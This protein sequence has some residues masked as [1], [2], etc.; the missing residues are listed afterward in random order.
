[1][2][3]LQ[4]LA[5]ALKAQ[6]KPTRYVAR[7]HRDI[8]ASAAEACRRALAHEATPDELADVRA[9]LDL[10]ERALAYCAMD[11]VLNDEPELG[12]RLRRR[13]ARPLRAPI[14]PGG[15]GYGP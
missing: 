12:G 2:T 5:D 1:M 8:L 6:P 10:I 3:P 11:Q 4:L 14:L 15:H 13:R 7:L 9:L